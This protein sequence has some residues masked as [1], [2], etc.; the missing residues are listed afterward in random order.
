MSLAEIGMAKPARADLC[1]TI[2]DRATLRADC[3]IAVIGAG[4]YGLAVAAHLKAAHVETQVFGEAM[5]F[6]RRNM[7]KGMRIRSSW[8]ATHIADPNHELSLDSYARNNGFRRTE[9][10]PL[11][12]FVHY[13]EWFQRRAVPDLD[14]RKVELVE[15]ADGGFRLRLEDGNT[16]HARRV[17]VAV[18]LAKQAYKPPEFERLPATL[19]SHSSEHADFDAFRGKR[20]A[21][22]GRGQSACESAVLL[23]EAGADVEI[24]SRGAIR[25]IGS[26][27]PGA[28]RERDLLWRVHGVLTSTGGVGPF[29]LNWLVDA[30]GI[31]R[32]LPLDLR[33]WVSTRSLRPAATAWL[34]PRF[35]GVRIRAG[36][37]VVSARTRAGRIALYLDDGAFTLFDHTLLATGYRTD[38]AKLGILAPGLLRRINRIEGHPL[39]STGFESSLRKIHFVG[40]AA[41]MSF[42]PLM[43][44]VWGAGY[45]AR[46]VTKSALASRS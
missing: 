23:H 4:P 40:S 16:V 12:D 6:W 17:V 30:P 24:I 45:A 35:G 28:D 8:R 19:A 20:V 7:P 32:H 38:I 27:I 11:E 43:R 42:G 44:F 10:L 15:A 31:V 29:P 41:V 9:P 3:D 14:T 46:A 1:V 2:V 34:R 26:E 39:L 5:A 36:R 33:D 22:I 13:G 37:T 18:G 21:V 25:W